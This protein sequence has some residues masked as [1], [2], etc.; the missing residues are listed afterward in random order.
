[1]YQLFSLVDP[2]DTVNPAQL[3]APAKLTMA[4]IERGHKKY[5][6]HHGVERS[7]TKWCTSIVLA[8]LKND[9]VPDMKVEINSK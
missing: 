3:K 9:S 7:D 5:Q 6:S 1:M 4:D 2:T 8:L